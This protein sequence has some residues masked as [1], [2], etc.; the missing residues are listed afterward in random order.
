MGAVMSFATGLAPRRLA[1]AAIV[2]FSGFVP[3]VDGWQPSFEDRTELPV[4]I[5]HGAQ[6]PVITVDFG[7]TA[8]DLLIA[9]GLAPQY[10][11]FEGGH[12]IDEGSLMPAADVIDVAL[13]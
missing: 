7:R 12:W 11:E 8:R 13:A 1:P 9:G 6:D 2:A 10:L 3:T 4:L 5:S